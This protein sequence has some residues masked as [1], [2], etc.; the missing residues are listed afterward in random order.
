MSCSS[1]LNSWR[2]IGRDALSLQLF[3]SN[4]VADDLPVLD[5]IERVVVRSLTTLAG[6]LD[7]AFAWLS[8]SG[9]TR[10]RLSVYVWSAEDLAR[11][12]TIIDASTG[13]TW[14][15]DDAAFVIGSDNEVRLIAEQWRARKRRCAATLHQTQRELQ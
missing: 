7:D 14:R 12:V 15:A 1:P 11:F 2:L 8:A 6:E 9:G 13:E 3:T 5:L 10:W 4:D